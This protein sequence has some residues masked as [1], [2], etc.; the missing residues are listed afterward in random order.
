M[1]ETSPRFQAER[2]AL[3]KIQIHFEFRQT[4]LRRVRMAAAAENL[5]YADF[6]RKA[7]GLPHAKTRRPRISLSFSAQD[8]AALARRYGESPAQPGVLKRCV[9]D[10]LRQRLDTDIDHDSPGR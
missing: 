9:I 3:G 5:S 1:A 7:V 8:L 4:L 10:E 6:V 2:Q